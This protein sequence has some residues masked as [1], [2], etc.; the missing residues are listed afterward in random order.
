ML[1][2]TIMINANSTKFQIEQNSFFSDK[3]PD[4]M[5]YTDNKGNCT[6]NFCSSLIPLEYR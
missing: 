6:N 5:S 3:C 1:K 2:Q 4:C